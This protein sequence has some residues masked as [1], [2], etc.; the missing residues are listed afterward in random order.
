MKTGGNSLGMNFSIISNNCHDSIP[1]TTIYVPCSS[2]HDSNSSRFLLVYHRIVSTLTVKTI[3]WH[4]H[5]HKY[6]RISVYCCY[7]SH[8]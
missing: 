1:Q 5:V 3:W 2:L 8:I 7:F 6:I 4:T